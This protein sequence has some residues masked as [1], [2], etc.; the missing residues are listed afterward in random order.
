[1]KYSI[2]IPTLNEE[3]LLPE[4][5]EQLSSGELKE[6]YDYQ[7]IVSDGGSTDKTIE[8]AKPFADKI[9]LNESGMKQ[10]IAIGRNVGARNA[11]GEVLIFLNGDVKMQSPEKFFEVIDKK[12]YNSTALALTCK[13]DIHPEQKI[14][15]DK[16]FMSFYNNYFHLLNI[17]GIGMGR[18]ECQVIRRSVFES[19]GGFNEKLP[20]GEDFELYTRI[21]KKGK[22]FFS[23]KIV[24]YESPRRFRKYG[25]L[26]IFLTW[27]LNGLFVFLKKKSL[28]KEWE[29]VR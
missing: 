7:I 10:N 13:V 23:R 22:I 3:K 6:K 2:I 9:I 5:L 18:G 28:S 20:A 19:I 4:L 11:D 26:Y 14:F 17:I 27:T 8:M 21:R 12:F 1:M 24:I 25:H 16:I 15:T 29:V